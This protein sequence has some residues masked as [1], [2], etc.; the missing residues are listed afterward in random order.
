VLLIKILRWNFP[1]RAFSSNIVAKN[2]QKLRSAIRC[3]FNWSLQ[4]T[5]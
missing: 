4:H 2:Q 1:Y 3:E 5:G